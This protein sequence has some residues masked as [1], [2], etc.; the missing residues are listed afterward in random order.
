MQGATRD[1]NAER[2]K[3]GYPTVELVGWAEPPHYDST[4]HKLYWAKDLKFSMP[5]P[6][7]STTTFACWDA[8]VCW[9]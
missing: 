4:A 7:P 3:A 8:A 6:I 5:P 9:C 1:A 2:A